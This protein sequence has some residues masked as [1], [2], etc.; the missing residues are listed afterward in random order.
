MRDAPNDGPKALKILNEHYMG[1]G[2]PR[3]IYLY[4]QLT[5]LQMGEDENVTDYLIRAETTCNSLKTAGENISDSL[6]MAITMKGLPD[7]FNTFCTVMTQKDEDC[8]FLD[9]KIALK[10]FEENERYRHRTAC[11]KDTIMQLNPRT[12]NPRRNIT[13]YTCGEPNHKSYQCHVN[14]GQNNGN[15]SNRKWCNNCKSSTHTTGECRKNKKKPS[16]DTVKT[17]QEDADDHSFVF[18][19]D[20]IQ[21]TD[22]VLTDVCNSILVDCG[23]TAHIITSKESFLSMQDLSTEKHVIELAD[24]SRSDNVVLG[25][26][27]A[28]ISVHDS[29]GVKHDIVLENALYIPS[30]KQNILSV[31]AAVRRGA[32]VNFGPNDAQLIAPDGTAFDINQSGRLYYLNSVK[33]S[34][35]VSRSS[36]NWHQTMGHCN[37]QD[38]L[39]LENVVDGMK[40]SDKSEFNCDTCTLG[41]MPQYRN[42]NPDRK[43]SKLFELVHCDLAGPIEPTA[44]EGFKYCLMFVDDYSGVYMVY[45]LKAKSDTCEATKKFLVDI[46]PFGQIKTLRS[47]NGTE[48]TCSGFESLLVQNKVRHEFSAPYSPHQNGTVERGWRTVFDMA[49]CMLIEANLPKFLWTYAVYTSVYIKNR[50]LNRRLGIT[51]FEAVTGKKPNL[52][53]MQIFGTS[54][55]AYIQNQSKLEPRCEKG[56]FIGYDKSSPAYLVYFK[57]KN[58]VKRVRCVKFCDNVV[59]KT[60]ACAIEPVQNVEQNIIKPYIPEN[61]LVEQAQ[62]N[63]QNSVDPNL[64]IDDANSTCRKSVRKLAKPVY[65]KD[66]VTMVDAPTDQNIDFLYQMGDFETPKTFEEAIQ[67]ENSM[68]WHQAMKDEISALDE[69]ETFE[70]TKL[71]A[72]ANLIGGKWVYTVKRDSD[73]EERYKARYVAKGYSQIPN[74]DYKDTFCPTA[75]ITS[76]RMLLQIAM[77]QNLKVHQMDVK[78]AFLNGPI[79]CELYV[80]QPKGFE[81]MGTKGEKLVCKLNK[82][83]YG[84]KQSGRI[85]NLLLHDYLIEQ[86]FKQSLTDMCVYTKQTHD[87][88]VILLVW[89][90]DII[91]AANSEDVLQNEKQTLSKRFKMK[92]LGQL[93]LFLNI[94]FDFEGDCVTMHQ[95]KYIEQMFDKFR[96]NDCKPKAAPCEMNVNKLRSSDSKPLEDSCLYR[97]IVGSLTYLMTC[98]R[99]DICYS[100]SMLSQF[101]E[102]PTKAH[103]EWAKHVLRYLK[104]TKSQSLN[105]RKSTGVKLQ[106]F[107]DSDWG[108]L[109]D[110]KSVSGYCFIMNT[111]SDMVCWKSRKQTCV[112]LSTCEAEYVALVSCVQE[113][114]FLRCLY[115]EFSG[116][117]VNTVDI[118]VDNQSAIALA[119][120]PVLHQRTKHIDIKYH[121]IRV[122]VQKGYILLK[123]IPSEQNLADMFTKPITRKRLDNLFV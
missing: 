38:I 24:G 35:K 97:Q 87:C 73:G 61:T 10:S 112:A 123:Y 23:A 101:L 113:A 18:K 54:C 56:V 65:L 117:K 36:K 68:K 6:L 45:F 13:C 16:S 115:E 72:G 95:S 84:L 104:G 106:G 90:D 1:K 14:K 9:Y 89:V 60:E 108:N 109:E 85:W 31:Q 44:R 4:T 55:F 51:P 111:N 21:N 19:A 74:I 27:N 26:G 59:Q 29:N 64:S 46:A 103:L 93:S 49:R 2:K 58:Q 11:E 80:E 99:L 110:R 25:K 53:K 70:Y 41:K 118:F 62:G 22:T 7:R 37:V 17:V 48:F 69:N 75:R 116:D 50:C 121:F 3:I 98:T 8:S 105:F 120:N 12:S 86:G 71:P 92:D 107:S 5:S 57:S 67:S 77:Q 52:S 119:K 88:Y 20:Y 94:Q 63:D 81:K 96:M 78:T 76:I 83:L 33:G 15:Q 42:R 47:D 102:H 79:D 114:K 30:Y 34:E 39:A 28:S 82:S 40:V 66:Y 91:I 32:N 122:E 100:V 43:A